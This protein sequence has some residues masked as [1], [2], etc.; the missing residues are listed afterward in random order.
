M[1]ASVNGSYFTLYDPI[2]R[3]I[4]KSGCHLIVMTQNTG[5]SRMNRADYVL[6]CGSSNRDDIG[7]Y[8]AT[9]LSE[10]LLVKYAEKYGK[11]YE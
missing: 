11:E 5:S 9:A 2:V 7:K 4:E 10:Y 8:M 6:S 3:A 1:I